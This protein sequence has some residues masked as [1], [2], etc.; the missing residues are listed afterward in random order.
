S[1]AGVRE[2]SVG[3]AVADH[4]G[5]RAKA[6]G[7]G[8]PAQP[9]RPDAYRGRGTAGVV[10]RRRGA[11]DRAAS[12]V[13]LP[14]PE[15][16]RAKSALPAAPLAFTVDERTSTVAPPRLETATAAPELEAAVAVTS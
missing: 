11:G 6:G 5:D 16:A 4:A 12:A 3:G 13:M 9:R 7:E 14:E 2:R 1:A 15:V 10:D 8:G